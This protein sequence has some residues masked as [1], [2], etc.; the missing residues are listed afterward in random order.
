MKPIALRLDRL[1]TPLATALATSDG[2]GGNANWTT[3]ANWAGDVAPLPGDDLV[4]PTM[5]QGVPPQAATVNDFPAGTA[6]HSIEITDRN[7]R[8]T[9]NGIALAAGLIAD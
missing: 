7:Y 9:G 6:F 5:G 1:Q 4:F 2:G 3:A 8:L